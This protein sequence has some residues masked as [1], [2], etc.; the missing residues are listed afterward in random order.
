M[1]RWSK[2]GGIRTKPVYPRKIADF[3]FA[4]YVTC[5]SVESLCNWTWQSE[6]DHPWHPE[7]QVLLW[8]YSRAQ[9][10]I[11][12]SKNTDLS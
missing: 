7:A 11:E 5:M 2:N 4:A 8:K 6:T 12:I 10:R 9:A 1:L 3:L